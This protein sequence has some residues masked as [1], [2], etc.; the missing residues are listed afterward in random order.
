MT[1]PVG[2][3]IKQKR[4]AK[5]LALAKLAQ[6]AGVS[7]TEIFRLERGERKALNL[8]ILRRIVEALEEPLDLFLKETGYLLNEQER[9]I[10]ED[11]DFGKIYFELQRRKE[12]SPEE[13]QQLADI[14]LRI[15]KSF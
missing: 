6:K 5:G 3:W 14:I 11:P 1:L 10:L 2:V 9:R 15:I 7:A 13:K 12:L 4:K 8:E